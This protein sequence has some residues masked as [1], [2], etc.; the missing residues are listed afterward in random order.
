M[1][2][3]RMIGVIFLVLSCG[4]CV[5]DVSEFTG[6]GTK[7]QSVVEEPILKSD[8][9]ALRNTLSRS[10]TNMLAKE[11]P[12]CAESGENKD[13]DK[14]AVIVGYNATDEK[15][16]P[17]Q[18]AIDLYLDTAGTLTIMYCENRFQ[19]MF[20]DERERKFSQTAINDAGTFASAMMGITSAGATATSVVGTTFGLWDGW[21][22]NYE[23]NYAITP[24]VTS[25]RRMVLAKVRNEITNIETDRSNQ[26]I[27]NFAV[28]KKYVFTLANYCSDVGM[29]SLI[30]AAIDV[31]AEDLKHNTQ[32]KT[33]NDSNSKTSVTIVPP[34]KSK[35]QMEQNRNFE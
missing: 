33:E 22:K 16:E 15:T 6:L 2:F 19:E 3:L 27:K 25:L 8:E 11:N 20:A 13:D 18:A 5:S 35:T 14:C 10:L 30:S 26:K 1:Y 21:F 24:D 28:A 7:K 9:K 4:A 34:V 31:K 32:N 12:Y 17:S 29:K 23:R